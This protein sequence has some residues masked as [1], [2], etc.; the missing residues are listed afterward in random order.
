MLIS[1]IMGFDKVFDNILEEGI[2]NVLN[3][4]EKIVYSVRKFIEEYG[5]EL[6]LEE[7]Y[8][9]IVIVIKVFESIGVLEFI[10]YMFKNY[11]IFVVILL[12]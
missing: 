7:G 9:N 3:R 4:Y 1:D 2:E 10:D 12:N 11:N 5:L 6:F 8:F